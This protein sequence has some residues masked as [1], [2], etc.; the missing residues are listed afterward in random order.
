MRSRVV[1]QPTPI[2]SDALSPFRHGFFGRQGGV[3]GGLY[4][5]LNCGLG[6]RDER[7]LVLDNRRRVA[8]A[9]GLP[10][11]PVLT[12]HQV[13]SATALVVDAPW[14]GAQP[15]ADALVTKT[16]GLV[17]GALAADCMPLLFADAEAGVVAAAHA[18]WRGA[19]DGIAAST[20]QAMERLGAMRRRI[21]VVVGPC[22]S[23]PNYEVGADFREQFLAVEPGYAA[24]FKC[25]PAGGKPRFDLPGF[26]LARLT[27]LGVGSAV[28]L[29][30]CTYGDPDQYFSYRRTTHRG[31][32]DYGRQIAV[33]AADRI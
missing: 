29:G 18:G 6:S 20:L 8:A 4:A 11:A 27:E 30:H 24:H 12:C 14:D 25:E 9:V 10:G 28:A 7:A 33:I 22:I 2:R 5:S 17:L 31:E 19:L 23:Q 16:P 1:S 15:K 3:S 26:M 21:R 13:H 32:P